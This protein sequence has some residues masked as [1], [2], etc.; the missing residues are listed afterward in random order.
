[1]DF[2]EETVEQIREYWFGGGFRYNKLSERLQCAVE[3][4]NFLLGMLN[5]AEEEIKG[6]QHQI[7]EAQ[8]FVTDTHSSKL[9]EVTPLQALQ[10]ISSYYEELLY[11]EEKNV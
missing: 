7:T 6:L 1:M 3:D 4:I 5:S 8:E 10:E 11:K 9:R 2:D